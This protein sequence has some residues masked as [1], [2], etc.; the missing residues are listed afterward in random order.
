LMPDNYVLQIINM[1][2]DLLK[3]REI[4]MIILSQFSR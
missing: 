1:I 3:N 2:H 4:K